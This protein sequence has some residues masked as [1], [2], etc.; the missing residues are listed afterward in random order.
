MLGN[1]ARVLLL[2][3]CA[4]LLPQSVLAQVGQQLSV[5]PALFEIAVVPEQTWQSAIKVVNANPYP[6]TVYVEPVNFAPRGEGGDGTLLPVP[7]SERE[8][9]T[10]AEWI[11][12]E[13]TSYELPPESSQSIPFVLSVPADAAPGGHYAAF[14]VGTKPPVEEGRTE[15]R[16]AQ[17]ITSLFFVRVA[18]EADERGVIREFS[19]EHWF[20][21]KPEMT[22]NLRFENSGNV[23]LRPQGDIVIT[24]M[25]GQERGVIPINRQGHFGNVL[26]NS[27]R[28]FSF[29]WRGERSLSD[30]GRY[31]AEVTLVYGNDARQFV[32]STTYFWVV[33]VVPVASALA[34]VS[35]TILLVVW[36]VRLYV[37]SLL[38]RAGFGPRYQRPYVREAARRGALIIERSVGVESAPMPKDARGARLITWA[39]SVGASLVR[40]GSILISRLPQGRRAVLVAS[41][42]LLVLL[43]IIIIFVRSAITP[44]R[45]YEIEYEDSAGGV[46]TS[47]EIMFRDER[48]EAS[49]ESRTDL[50]IVHIINESGVAG[51]AATIALMLE[52]QQ[53]RVGEVTTNLTGARGKTVVVINSEVDTDFGL[54]L[55]QDL[56]GALLSTAATTSV[57]STTETSFV[58]VYLGKDVSGDEGGYE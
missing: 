23:H 52:T 36:L 53:Y 29:T 6:L 17:I 49:L 15:L 4:V 18:G 8:G 19:P 22:L 32:T 31:R 11:T 27:I 7:E 45:S 44:Q 56:G 42:V 39:Q 43:T 25:W 54:K 30:M 34:V 48:R 40:A 24:N 35:L 50:P 12:L 14:T 37:R 38:D 51:A 9:V 46:V 57:A 20:Q 13:S 28:K 5:S 10:V 2:V 1:T 33:P 47:D 26:P 3:V 58:T 55:S 41:G 16:T 21:S